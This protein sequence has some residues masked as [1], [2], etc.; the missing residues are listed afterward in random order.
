MAITAKQAI[1]AVKGS[2]GYISVIAGRLG[3]SRS[4]VYNLRDKFATFA[5]ALEDE[6]ERQKDFAEGKLQEQIKDG[7]MT[8]I[9]FYLKTQAKER[10]YVERQQ[11]QQLNIDVTLLT[12][13][14]LIRIA[15]GEDVT[16]VL[17]SVLASE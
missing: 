3:C 13:E 9:I 7:N 6:R 11:V 8:A 4:H 2:G 16:A 5:E 14:Q 12:D 10:G 1:D 17:A 15:A